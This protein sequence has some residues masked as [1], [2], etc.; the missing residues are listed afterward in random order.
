MIWLIL[1]LAFILRVINLNQSLWLDEATHVILSSKSIYSIIFERIGDFHP[2]LSY[3]IFHFWIMLGTSE[4][5]LRLLPVIFGVATVFVTFKIANKLFDKKIAFLSA[6]FL[7]I[8]PYHIYYSQEVRMYSLAALLAAFSMWSLITYKRIWYILSSILLVLTHYMGIF[9]LIAQ[10]IYL[11]WERKKK[12]KDVAVDYVF[13]AIGFLFWLPLFLGQL[14]NG[15]KADQ[16]LPGWG[17]VLSLSWIKA[18]P[19]LLLKFSIGRINFDDKFIYGIVIVFV[20]TIL[21][22]IFYKALSSKRDT[23]IIMLWLIL[24]VLFTFLISFFIPMFQPFRLLFVLPAFYII[25]AV[26]IYELRRFK[27]LFLF[28]ILL[29]SL[30]GLLIYNT[31]QTFWREDWRGAINF[32]RQNVKDENSLVLA[33]TEAF[34]PVVWYGNDLNAIGAV[35]EFPGQKDQIFTKLNKITSSDIYFFEYLQALTDPNKYIQLWLQEN[36]YALKATY[37]FN[38]VGFIYLYQKQIQYFGTI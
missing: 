15:V 38:G 34:P 11:F 33:W 29:I 27:N 24:P 26:G 5:W 35:N 4:I 23:K 31:N 8:A 25:L 17:A 21:G 32:L 18:I 6:L 36:N 16:Y 37:N 30:G 2:P 7:T 20:L 28:L 14:L 10:I 9:L 1:I 12:I 3:L 19:L 22:I 13:I